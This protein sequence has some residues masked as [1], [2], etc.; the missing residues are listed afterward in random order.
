MKAMIKGYLAGKV[1]RWHTHA[2][3]QQT[4]ADHSHG[5]ALLL[6]KLCPEPTPNMIKYALLH[7]MGE[8]KSGDM[9][10]SAKNWFGDQLLPVLDKLEE[11]GIYDVG[12]D[13]PE[14]TEEERLWISVVDRIEAILFLQTHCINKQQQIILDS[15]GVLDKTAQKLNRLENSL[16]KMPFELRPSK[17]ALDWMKS[18]VDEYRKDRINEL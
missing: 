16:S 10:S 1:R 7:D 2:T 17:D 11:G 13:L 9:P 6:M 15:S 18:V 4:V 3:L 8:W 12:F 5:V 14:L